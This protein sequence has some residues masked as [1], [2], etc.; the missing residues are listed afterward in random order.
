[1]STA[2]LL[3]QM[4]FNN[5]FALRYLLFVVPYLMGDKREPIH[6]LGMILITCVRIRKKRHL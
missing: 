5:N 1:M 3:H 6:E 4:K 2:I